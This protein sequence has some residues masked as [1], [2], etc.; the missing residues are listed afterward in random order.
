MQ[1]AQPAINGQ[2]AQSMWEIDTTR[3]LPQFDLLERTIKLKDLLGLEWTEDLLELPVKDLL[4]LS[5]KDLL[6]FTV[7]KST[8]G[9]TAV[10]TAGCTAVKVHRIEVPNYWGLKEGNKRWAS[11]PLFTD[12][13]YK[14][15]LVVIPNGLKYTEGYGKCVGVWL[16]PLCGDMDDELSWPAKV[17]M[18][19]RIQSTKEDIAIPMREYSW[20]RSET[21]CRYPAFNFDLTTFAHDLVETPQCCS[22]GNISMI[23]E[24]RQM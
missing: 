13:G 20:E 8:A 16:D 5:V 10:K 19:L 1:L 4:K 23:I 11:K 17:E 21:K 12:A 24:E 18:S 22:N 3:V 9:C 15:R 6:E 14:F 7:K 2:S